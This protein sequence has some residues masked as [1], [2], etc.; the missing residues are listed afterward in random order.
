MSNLRVGNI[1]AV[2]ASCEKNIKLSCDAP[3]SDGP[4]PEHVHS[5]YRNQFVFKAKG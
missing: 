5:N 4:F 3:L 1:K 2:E